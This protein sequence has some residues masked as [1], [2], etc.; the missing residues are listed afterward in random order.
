M[1]RACRL[2][3]YEENR[4]VKRT[5][6]VTAAVAAIG[7]AVYVGQLW[8]QT[9]GT[10]PTPPAEMKTKIALVNLTYVI[11]NY[12]KFATFQEELKTAVAPFQATDARLKAETE[13]LYKELQDSKTSAERRDAIEKELMAKKRQIE[14]NKNDANKALSKKQEEQLRI[15]YMDVRT[16]AEKVALSR[17]FE[18]VLHFNDAVNAQDY[19]SAQNVVRKMQAGALMPMYYA[20]SLDISADIVTTLNSSYKAPAPAAGTHH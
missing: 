10:K 6:I 16:V 18:M 13:K 20:G 3:R 1:D 7:L 4:T 14:D 5:V 8:A 19:W 2:S 9:G 12:A 15:L 17:G 11:K